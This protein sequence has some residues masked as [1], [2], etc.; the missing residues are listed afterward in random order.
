MSF[1]RLDTDIVQNGD[2]TAVAGN[3]LNNPRKLY[4]FVT[5]TKHNKQSISSSP[6][7]DSSDDT[8]GLLLQECNEKVQDW[9]DYWGPYYGNFINPSLEPLIYTYQEHMRLYFNTTRFQ[10][11]VARTSHNSWDNIKRD[12]IMMFYSSTLRL[13]E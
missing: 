7:Q 6:T 4:D 11:L 12:D 5:R 13:L 2:S 3:K 9:G 1:V 10:R 8:F